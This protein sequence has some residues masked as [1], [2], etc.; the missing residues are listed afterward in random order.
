ME[1]ARINPKNPQGDYL[2]RPTYDLLDQ[3]RLLLYLIFLTDIFSLSTGGWS[4]EY[5]PRFSKMTETPERRQTFIQSVVRFLKE[6]NLDGLS[7]SWIYPGTRTSNPPEEEK[8]K[9]SLLVKETYE[10]F[11]AES[12]ETSKR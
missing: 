3:I 11:Q 6:H 10:A 1:S 9:F 7:Y 8:N 4:H 12:S 2:L 5:L